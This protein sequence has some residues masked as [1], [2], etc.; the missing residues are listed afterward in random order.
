M[1]LEAAPSVTGRTSA[2]AA[3]RSGPST[4]S[5]PCYIHDVTVKA[6]G[7]TVEMM[8]DRFREYCKRY[9]FQM[10]QGDGGYVHYQCRVTLIKKRRS[11]EIAGLFNDDVFKSYWTP[12]SN[13]ARDKESFYC[14]KKDTRVDGPWKDSDYKPPVVFTRQ[15]REFAEFTKYPWQVT[16]ERWCTEWDK[17]TIYWVYDEKGCNGKSD[18]VEWL[19][20]NGLAS[21]VPPMRNLEDIMQ[22]CMSYTAKAYLID[23]PRAM[24]KEHLCEFYSGIESLKNGFLYDKRYKGVK[25]WQDRPAIVIFSNTKPDSAAMS[26]DRWSIWEIEN[27]DLVPLNETARRAVVII[28]PVTDPLPVASPPRAAAEEYDDGYD[29]PPEG[30]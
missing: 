5:S 4:S 12:T 26:R 14:L 23:F 30:I 20:T 16:V 24:K 18:L 8:H 3:G 13:N 27:Y 7:V 6:E 9:V 2:S 10:E 29:S 11:T 22:F 15:M 17:R 1:D 28:P 21:V 25:K 19:D